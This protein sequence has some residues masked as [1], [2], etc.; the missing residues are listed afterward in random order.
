M[1]L[2]PMGGAYAY[3]LYFKIKKLAVHKHNW[4]IQGHNAYK[5]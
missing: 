1:S 5:I 2:F 3:D 4:L